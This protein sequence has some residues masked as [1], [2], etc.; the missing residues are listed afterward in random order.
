M[1]IQGQDPNYRQGDFVNVYPH[2]LVVC[3]DL[4][5]ASLSNEEGKYW[6]IANRNIAIGTFLG[7]HSREQV[8]SFMAKIEKSGLNMFVCA[9]CSMTEI[10]SGAVVSK[11]RQLVSM[12]D[13]VGSATGGKTRDHR[14]VTMM[15]ND[16]FNKT[17]LVSYCWFFDADTQE[18]Q[19]GKAVCDLCNQ[20]I[21]HGDGYS[22]YSSAVLPA[23][24][25]PTGN[26]F[27]CDKC[28]RETVNDR[29]WAEPRPQLQSAEQLQRQMSREEMLAN[30]RA[31]FELFKAQNAEGIVL[32]CKRL[33]LSPDEAKQKARELAVLWWKDKDRSRRETLQFFTSPELKKAPSHIPPREAQKQRKPW[34]KFWKP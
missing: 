23:G 32:T 34:W 16:V 22:F 24:D 21:A 12:A 3:T 11:A 4:P 15:C 17:A 14:I 33:G 18:A 28:T 29:M 10:T 2:S 20:E 9:D 5:S 19:T 27:L 13:K 6:I 30:P 1:S 26:M 8:E 25:E 31:V 7:M